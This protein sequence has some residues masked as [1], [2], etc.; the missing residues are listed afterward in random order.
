MWKTVMLGILRKVGAPWLV[1]MNVKSLFSKVS[2]KKLY[3]I[4]YLIQDSFDLDAC[5]P[6][7]TSIVFDLFSFFR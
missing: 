4:G 5:E 7:L 2:R 3:N 1:N 6:F